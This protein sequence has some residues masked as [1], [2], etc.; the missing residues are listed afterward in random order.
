M[1]S[2]DHG[3]ELG[4]H[5]IMEVAIDVHPSPDDG[6]TCGELGQRLVRQPNLSVKLGADNL[7]EAVGKAS[8]NLVVVPAVPGDRNPIGHPEILEK[9]T[10]C[11]DGSPAH[12]QRGRQIIQRCRL[13][14]RHKKSGNTSR[15]PWETVALGIE[16]HPLDEACNGRIHGK[17]RGL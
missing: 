5:E 4:P 9:P 15:N 13:G 1:P 2:W 8:G 11:A 12:L 7:E 16:A 14:T 3:V 6:I 10:V 17:C